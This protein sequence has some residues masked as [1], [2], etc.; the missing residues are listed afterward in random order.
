[1]LFSLTALPKQNRTEICVFG[2]CF[3]C[4]ESE[5]VCGDES[6]FLEG[7]ILQLIPG[8]LAKYRSPWQRTYKDNQKAEW[9]ENVNY[10]EYYNT[11]GFLQFYFKYQFL[12]F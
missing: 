5:S 1:M 3:Y 6:G 4:K 9:E 8:T 10:C 11:D 7:A 2:K 12:F